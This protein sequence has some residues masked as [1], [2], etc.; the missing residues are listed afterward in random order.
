MRAYPSKIAMSATGM[1]AKLVS[2]EMSL[3]GFVFTDA[4]FLRVHWPKT[5]T[6]TATPETKA[7]QK[8]TSSK[9]EE[10]RGGICGLA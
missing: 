5:I 6:G 1:M 8:I 9:R 4:A 7:T 3:P 2:V 10:N